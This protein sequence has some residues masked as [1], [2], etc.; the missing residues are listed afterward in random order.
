MRDDDERLKCLETCEFL[1]CS[2]LV[3]GMDHINNLK[4]KKLRVIFCYHFGSEDL[5]G[6]PNKVELVESIKYFLE[7]IGRVLFIDRGGYVVINEGVH[8]YGVDMGEIYIF[9]SLVG[10]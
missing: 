6:I 5:K 9:F 4:V 2:V 10:I 1:V 8:E 3:F 7:R